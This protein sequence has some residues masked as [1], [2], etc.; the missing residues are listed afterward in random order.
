MKLVIV[1]AICALLGWLWRREDPFLNRPEEHRGYNFGA[2]PAIQ[3]KLWYENFDN[4][5]C[6]K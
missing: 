4:T 2:A 1:G 6:D 3:G 5:I